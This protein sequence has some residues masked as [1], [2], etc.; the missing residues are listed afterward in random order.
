MTTIHSDSTMEATMTQTRTIDTGRA[1]AGA[2]ALIY[3]FQGLGPWWLQSAAALA[4]AV[5]LY[6][7]HPA[8]LDSAKDALRRWR[9]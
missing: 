8:D 7:A 5:C 4:G 1:V 6:F 9:E 2:C 3:A